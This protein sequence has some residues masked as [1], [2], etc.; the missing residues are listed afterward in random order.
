MPEL[1]AT[2]PLPQD[3]VRIHT[4]NRE[5]GKARVWQ[6]PGPAFFAYHDG[7]AYDTE[8]GEMF[9]LSS[10]IPLCTLGSSLLKTRTCKYAG[11]G[12]K[13]AAPATSP[14]PTLVYRLRDMC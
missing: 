6:V 13:N 8:G 1:T 3:G 14:H 4:I 10:G 2:T 9:F 7:N 5:S 12:F 11:E